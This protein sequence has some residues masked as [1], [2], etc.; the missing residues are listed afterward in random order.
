MGEESESEKE[1]TKEEEDKK[2]KLL[3]STNEL[4]AESRRFSVLDS[5]VFKSV[6]HQEITSPPPE[7]SFS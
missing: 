4:D 2:M 3:F 7:G 6:H 1:E 5:K